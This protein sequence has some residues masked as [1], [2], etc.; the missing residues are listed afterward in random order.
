MRLTLLLLTTLLLNSF[1]I[2]A[3]IAGNDRP[4]VILMVL[5]DLNDWVGFLEGHPQTITP[6][7]DKL[8]QR[9]TVFSNAYCT[10]PQCAPS[11]ASFLTGKDPSYANLYLGNDVDK[12]DFRGNFDSLV[13]TIPEILKDTGNYFTVVSN[14]IFHGKN[15]F[16][17]VTDIDFD[18]SSVDACEKKKSWSKI[19]DLSSG[20]EPS[21][22]PFNSQSV[23]FGFD[24]GFYSDSLERK[25]I[26]YRGVDSALEFLRSYFGNPSRFCDHPFFLALGINKPHTPFDLPNR[27]KPEYYNQD[28][29]Q[30]PYQVPYNIPYNQMPPNGVVMPPQPPQG[31]WADYDSLPFIGK[32][33]S[34]D[35]NKNLHQQFIEWPNTLSAG[36]PLVETGLDTAARLNILSEAHRANSI[37]GYL[38]AIRYADDQVGR[39]MQALETRS[40]V[41][42]N[43]VI[44]LISDHGYSLG[45]KRH[46]KKV[47]LWETDIH[48]PMVIVDPRKTGNKVC[49][50]TVSLLDL[51]PTILELTGI[52]EPTF[53]DGSRYLDGESLVPLIDNPNMT[54]ERPALT[55]VTLPNSYSDAGCNNHYSVR[56]EEF[57]YIRYRTNGAA[58][59]VSSCDFE[60]SRIQ[61]ELYHIGLN[62]EI[63]PHEWNNL[64]ND[65]AYRDLMDYLN[66]WTPEGPLFKQKASAVNISYDNIPCLL[67]KTDTVAFTASLITENGISIDPDTSGFIFSWNSELLIDTVYASSFT[68]ADSLIDSTAFAD[69]EFAILNLVARDTATGIMY[70]NLIRLSLNNQSIP[71]AN[72]DLTVNGITLTIENYIDTGFYNSV[73]WE[74]EDGFKNTDI[75]PG[76]HNFGM[77]DTFSVIHSLFYGNDPLNQCSASNTFE[78]S[79]DTSAF[80]SLCLSPQLVSLID[81]SANRMKIEW[82]DVYGSIQYKR[83]YRDI[84]KNGVWKYNVGIIAPFSEISSLKP[85]TQYE[86]QVQAV[87][88][89][90]GIDTSD[91]S[92]PIR[93]TTLPCEPPRNISIFDI[94]ATTATISWQ[95]SMEEP[96][97]SQ[98]IYKAE[99]GGPPVFNPSQ[100]TDT[101]TLTGL[102][103]AAGYLFK[104]RSTC[105]QIGGSLTVNGGLSELFTFNTL[106]TVSLRLS[107]HD[108][109]AIQVMPNPAFGYANFQ[110]ESNQAGNATMLIINETGSIVHSESLNLSLGLQ[111]VGVDVSKLV[112]GHY[113]VH[114]NQADQNYSSKLIVIDY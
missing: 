70:N 109:G 8:A 48:V 113:L 57:H 69:N 98:L 110:F 39:V 101:L 11:R 78:I 64:G 49:H 85:N 5:D 21:P 74:Y 103:P 52:E 88:D 27:F 82:Q 10:V 12:A 84:I 61:E 111:T 59:S 97:A 31:N 44:I 95:K 3:Q 51:F 2:R 15:M 6:H 22:T 58:D 79:I 76:N 96:I 71:S 9:G 80:D 100:T 36:L 38:S 104:M 67:G 23:G 16:P 37:L 18:T 112:A 94:T 91:W 106:D 35:Y 81:R 72:F 30:F 50:R 83:R 102:V 47:G 19:T 87:C 20:V 46:W 68:W 75:I 114:V 92:Y 14:K 89:A 29:Y 33:M 105:A 93:P 25:G 99:V 4:N 24:W 63:D 90:S 41:F 53:A 108:P 17:G 45:Q 55:G 60:N 66:Q 107:P 73:L 34:T 62:R 86:I 42:N 56:T 77:P 1:G 65:P 40:D 7:M 26:D 28:Y 13:Y 54:W 32:I 43:T